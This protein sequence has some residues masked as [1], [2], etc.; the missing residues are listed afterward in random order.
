MTRQTL[1][2]WALCFTAN[3]PTFFP[4]NVTLDDYYFF[5][6][7][8]RIETRQRPCTYAITF[9]VWRCGLHEWRRGMTSPPS[10]LLFLLRLCLRTMQYSFSVASSSRS[11]PP[12][13][14]MAHQTSAAAGGFHFTECPPPINSMPSGRFLPSFLPSLPCHRTGDDRTDLPKVPSPTPRG[15]C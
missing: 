3:F 1:P 14:R 11:I 9:R 4:R 13:I 2:R 8:G 15:V 7:V 10:S 5:A 6:F 12:S